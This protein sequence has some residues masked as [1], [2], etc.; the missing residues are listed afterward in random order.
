MMR[1]C[2]IIT[3]LIFVATLAVKSQNDTMYIFQDDNM[4]WKYGVSDIDSITF[5]A[6]D[7]IPETPLP[8]ITGYEDNS[9]IDENGD[10]FFPWGFNYC[11]PAMVD[12]VEDF[13][14]MEDAWDIIGNDFQEM[15]DYGANT[16]RIHLQ[17]VKFMKDK[18]TPDT[19]AFERLKRYVQLSEENDIYLIVTGLGSYRLS[20]TLSWYDSLNDSLRW[21]TQKLFWKT[22]AATIKDNSCVFAYDLINEPVVAVGCD[23]T[24]TTWYP[25]GTY[26]GYQFVQNVSINPENNYWETMGV[27]ADEMTG[28]IRSED[29][30]TMITTGLLPLGLISVLS[31][32]FDIIST[33]IYPNAND[34]FNS[35]NYVINNQSDKP[36]LIEEFYN[37]SCSTDDLVFFLDQIDGYYNG[38]IGHYMGKTIEEYDTTKLVDYIHKEFLE[39]FME[40]NPNNEPLEW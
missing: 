3:V 21:A 7:T 15:H 31:P 35:V 9:F 40:N 8:K 34:I 23:S 37:L 32:H 39:F 17:Y 1:R 24:H 2:I 10:T 26:G 22:V 28:A 30:T 4:I 33:H 36:F 27:W 6:G 25:G 13:W 29:E 12:L 16:V 38:L 11:N 18:D 5:Y 14:M 20:D 19:I